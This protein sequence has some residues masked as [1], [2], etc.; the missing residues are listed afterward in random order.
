MAFSATHMSNSNGCFKVIVPSKEHFANASNAPSIA[1]APPISAFIPGMEPPTFKDNPPVSKEIPLPTNAI[2]LSDASTP[3]G[4]NV[5][6]TNAGSLPSVA[7][8]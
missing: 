7:A 6:R 5:K 1:A 4:T 8:D 2:G 3:F